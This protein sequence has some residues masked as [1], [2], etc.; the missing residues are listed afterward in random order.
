MVIVLENDMGCSG[1]VNTLGPERVRG[2]L[3]PGNRWRFHDFYNFNCKSTLED[4]KHRNILGDVGTGKLGQSTAYLSGLQEFVIQNKDIKIICEQMSFES[5]ALGFRKALKYY[6]A[7]LSW[8][9]S[10]KEKYLQ[11]LQEFIALGAD[12]TR[13]RDEGVRRQIEQ[14]AADIPNSIVVVLRGTA[15]FP[16]LD[17]IDA[18]RYRC[19]RVATID[20]TEPDRDFPAYWFLHKYL[21][22]G[23]RALTENEKMYL[24]AEVPFNAEIS[25]LMDDD[26]IQDV[27][28]FGERHRN[29]L[30][31]MVPAEVLAEI[32]K[33]V[34]PIPIGIY[35]QLSWDCFIESLESHFKNNEKWSIE[36]GESKFRKFKDILENKTRKS[37]GHRIPTKVEILVSLDEAG[38]KEEE[39]R[40]ISETIRVYESRPN[41]YHALK[42][43]ELTLGN[44]EIKLFASLLNDAKVGAG[45]RGRKNR[46]VSQKVRVYHV[47]DLKRALLI[48]KYGLYGLPDMA[49]FLT[50][51][52]DSL[53]MFESFDGGKKSDIVILALDLE[54]TAIQECGSF[55]S[56]R[57]KG[58][59]SFT[60]PR[61]LR[62]ELEKIYSREKLGFSWASGAGS[63]GRLL[64]KGKIFGWAVPSCID[65]DDTLELTQD[66]MMQEGFMSASSYK[67]FKR[68]L[69]GSRSKGKDRGEAS[70]P[71]GEANQ[72]KKSQR[73]K[74][75]T[76]KP[77]H[78]VS[79]QSHDSLKTKLWKKYLK[80]KT[81]L[82]AWLPMLNSPYLPYVKTKT[83]DSIESIGD[84]IKPRYSEGEANS[85]KGIKNLIKTNILGSH[86]AVI[87]D[88]GGPHSVAMAVKLIKK[89]YQPVVM[90]NNIAYPE[91]MVCSE[92]CLAALLYF[93]EE[94]KSLKEKRIFSAYSPPVFILDI[95]RANSRTYRKDIDNT[96]NYFMGD[97]PSPDVLKK[98]GI[99]KIVYLNEDDRNGKIHPVYQS[100]KILPVDLKPIVLNWRA[101]NIKIVY[102]GVRPWEV[103]TFT[104]SRKKKKIDLI[105][106]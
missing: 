49:M 38:F 96:Y 94:I 84:R 80:R 83:M 34:P 88:S 82:K 35:F 72:S 98:L 39:I 42:K 93:A 55:Y 78:I 13:L 81:L 3:C 54:D 45:R 2:F 40:V 24:S 76:V 5:F 63:V 14:L 71:G 16:L 97:F 70:S 22:F 4:L 106:E 1:I 57:K 12:H 36:D 23:P 65:V 75:K 10:N 6:E 68:A 104:F 41:Q 37:P 100:I 20:N 102:T 33:D 15:H 90:L 28:T 60:V 58:G 31:S 43:G 61:K 52:Y 48:L 21:L 91:G 18:N 87:L 27:E 44:F 11:L 69:L 105:L 26:T 66:L 53:M 32:R 101:K 59:K 7:K 8:E 74:K 17:E 64:N 50:D 51:P 25:K 73:V 62:L 95:H 19:L 47:T 86:T 79:P 85:E 29:L 67:K 92:Q 56:F 89:G 77:I 9:A 46:S 99:T 103:K 30:R